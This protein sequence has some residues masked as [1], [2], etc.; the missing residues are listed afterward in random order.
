MSTTQAGQTEAQ[1]CKQFTLLCTV[2][3]AVLVVAF[4]F[5]VLMTDE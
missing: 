2:V 4:V 3:C 1:V 5:E